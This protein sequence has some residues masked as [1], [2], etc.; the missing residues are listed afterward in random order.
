[1]NIDLLIEVEHWRCRAE[2]ARIRA[3]MFDSSDLRVLMLFIADT[4][5]SLIEAAEWHLAQC[6]A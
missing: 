6:A 2:E 4:Y 1:M 3:E 5:A